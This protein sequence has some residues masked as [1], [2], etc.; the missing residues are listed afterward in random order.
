MKFKIA[1]VQFS[2]KQFAPEANLKKAEHYIKK[3]SSKADIIV[4]PEDFV[5]GSIE[6]KKELIDTNNKYRKNQGKDYY[7][8]VRVKVLKSTDLNRKISGWIKGVCIRCGIV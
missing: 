3:A 4:F 2:I 8:L 5:T 7:G 1:V 6:G